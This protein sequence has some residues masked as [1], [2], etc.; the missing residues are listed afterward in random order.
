MKPTVRMAS[1]SAVALFRL[2]GNKANTAN[3][4][5]TT[6]EHTRFSSESRRVLLT[7]VFRHRICP[8]LIART[9]AVCR[10][11]PDQNCPF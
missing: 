1:G 8:R 11:A 2:C 5:E 9:S 7:P 3:R 6:P 10:V 4:H